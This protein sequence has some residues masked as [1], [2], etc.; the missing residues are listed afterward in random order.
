MKG[1]RHPYRGEQC[2]WYVRNRIGEWLLEAVKASRVIDAEICVNP[3]NVKGEGVQGEEN[4][5]NKRRYMDSFC[6]S[7]KKR[8]LT[9]FEIAVG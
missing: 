2:G 1:A 3:R 7:C 4:R 8:T 9:K 6:G 5:G